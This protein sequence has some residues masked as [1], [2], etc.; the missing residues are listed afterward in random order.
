MLTTNIAESNEMQ[1]GD[2]A[3]FSNTHA[4]NFEKNSPYKGSENEASP[5]KEMSQNEVENGSKPEKMGQLKLDINTK[6]FRPVT[7][8]NKKMPNYYPQQQP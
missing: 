8:P 1:P 6:P 4:N 3:N 7:A 5:F 2:N